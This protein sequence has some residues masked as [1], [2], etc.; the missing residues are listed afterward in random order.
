MYR[1]TTG[2]QHEIRAD[3][4]YE[5]PMNVI[6]A[7]NATFGGDHSP[8]SKT[9]LSRS[10]FHSPPGEYEEVSTVKA[11]RDSIKAAQRHQYQMVESGEESEYSHLQHAHGGSRK[12]STN[13]T[14]T[15][16]SPSMPQSR[17]KTSITSSLS[18]S[19]HQPGPIFDS[20]EYMTIGSKSTEAQPETGERIINGDTGY[21]HINPQ[22]LKGMDT[23]SGEAEGPDLADSESYHQLPSAFTGLA[24]QQPRG[25]I[26]PEQRQNSRTPHTH[27][28]AHR[29]KSATLASEPYTPIETANV[30]KRNTYSFTI[31][32][33][34]EQYVSERGHTYHLLERS[35]EHQRNRSPPDSNEGSPKFRIAEDDSTEESKESSSIP[36]YSHVDKLP[37]QDS[38]KQKEETD[39]S[40]EQSDSSSLQES[41]MESSRKVIPPYSQVDKSKKKNR[42]PQA[43]LD[44]QLNP[45]TH[46]YH[47]LERNSEDKTEKLSGEKGGPIYHV[48]DHEP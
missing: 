44:T 12:F 40:K 17:G 13:S 9:S 4:G 23:T 47:T 28:P 29:H 45:E 31:V 3:V 42:Q 1:A 32:S 24:E 48:I 14:G 20:P 10:T 38:N 39:K 25:E 16:R 22:A 19:G 46:H 18:L 6:H 36:P 11:A 37:E 15:A 43:Q 21:S 34:D 30:K 26:A 7:H 33:T 27:P 35:D 5:I 2:D 8:G 41:S